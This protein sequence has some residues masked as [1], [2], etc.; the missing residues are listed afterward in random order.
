M[1]DP[2]VVLFE[3][4]APIP[5]RTWK[6]YKGGPRWVFRVRRRTNAENLGQRIYSWWRPKGYELVIAGRIP[7]MWDLATVWHVEPDGHDSGDVCGRH[8]RGR[9]LILWTW[10]HRHHLKVTIR[11]KQKLARWLF[12]RCEHCGGKSRKG[13]EVN[14]SRSWH[15]EPQRW[16]KSAKGLYHGECASI[17]HLKNGLAEA[18]E[19]LHAAAVSSL[20]LELRGMDSTK[21]WR[22]IYNANQAAKKPTATST[23]VPS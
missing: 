22:V 2:M 14:R 4:H 9:A 15:G 1:H 23:E 12:Q 5:V 16:G 19:A 13:H 20:D 11:P 6:Q 17:I 18:N 10:R 21:A 7:K 8:P 3:I